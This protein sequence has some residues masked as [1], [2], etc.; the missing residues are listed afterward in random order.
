MEGSPHSTWHLLTT[1]STQF[2]SNLE[3][4]PDHFCDASVFYFRVTIVQATGIPCEFTDVFVQLRLDLFET[5]IKK[6][7]TNTQAK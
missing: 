6:T 3:E 1:T 7:C 5:K 2:V 4:S